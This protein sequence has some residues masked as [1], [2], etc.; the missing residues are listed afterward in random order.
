ME[1][2]FNIE[3]AKEFGVLEAILLNNMWFWIE[4][5]KANNVNYFDNEYWTY[6]SVNA[7]NKLFPYASERKIQYSLKKLIKEG[8]LIKGNYN[9]S[10]RD[11]T[12]WYAFSKKGKCIMQNCQMHSVNLSNAFGKNVRP[13]PYINTYSKPY[14]KPNN[15]KEKI[16]DWLDKE[17]ELDSTKVEEIEEILKDF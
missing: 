13:L 14:N 15:I 3:I 9:K 1:H 8:I 12:S 5:N 4:K 16:C 10:S 7:F 17:F 6:N 11:R 2:S